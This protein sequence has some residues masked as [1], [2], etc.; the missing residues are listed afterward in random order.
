MKA[1][2]RLVAVA[3]TVLLSL[4]WGRPASASVA[5]ALTLDDLAGHA[6]RIDVARLVGRTSAWEEGRIFTSWRLDVVRHVAGTT[7]TAGEEIVVRT[8][9][10]VVDRIGQLVEGEATFSADRPTLAFFTKADGGAF[11][12]VGRAQGTYAVANETL[13]RLPSSG[14]VLVRPVRPPRV[15]A[16]PAW[17]VLH[18]M[19][20]EPASRAIAAAWERTHGHP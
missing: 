12:V 10:G 19:H 7:G 16:E 1:T 15:P 11:V 6:E 9:G 14:L 4:F 2:L 5:A 17:T 13:V 3:V 8:R 20:L 18:G